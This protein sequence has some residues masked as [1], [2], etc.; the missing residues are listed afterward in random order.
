MS[1]DEELDKVK[2][3]VFGRPVFIPSHLTRALIAGGVALGAGG[4][5]VVSGAYAVFEFRRTNFEEV[6]AMIKGPK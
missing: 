3:V 1:M 5:A 4:I 6:A 2:E